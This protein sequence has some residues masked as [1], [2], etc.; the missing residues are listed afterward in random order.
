MNDIA[1]M[2]ISTTIKQ[3]ESI[4]T[5]NDLLSCPFCGSPAKFFRRDEGWN[6]TIGCSESGCIIMRPKGYFLTVFN[7]T[8]AWNKRVN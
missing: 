6:V 1:S 5:S 8:K 7:A 3:S 2:N 4:V